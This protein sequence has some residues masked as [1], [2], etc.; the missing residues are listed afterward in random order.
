M[1]V[2]RVHMFAQSF[3]EHSSRVQLP[4]TL[5]TERSFHISHPR[6]S[7]HCHLKS[8]LS[9]TL[10]SHHT[11][12][13]TSLVVQWL[14]LHTANAG[15]EK[16]GSEVAHQVQLCNPMDCNLWGSSVH[17]IFQ[18][19][20]L[21]W[22]AISFSR[23]SSWLRDWTQVSCIAGRLYCEPPGKPYAGDLGSVPGQ[24][25]T[26]HMPKLKILCATTKTWCRQINKY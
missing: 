16:K 26:F 24:G 11:M 12:S 15:V 7:C 21:E 10:T 17:V 13:E 5:P 14:R 6:A 19:R 9:K 25:T 3:G 1:Y 4:S 22:V 18:A 20:T 2:F 8:F 23:G